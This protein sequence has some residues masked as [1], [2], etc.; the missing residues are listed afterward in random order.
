MSEVWAW[1]LGPQSDC[2]RLLSALAVLLTWIGTRRDHG[3]DDDRDG[4]GERR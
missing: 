4:A 2:A 3:A 1:L